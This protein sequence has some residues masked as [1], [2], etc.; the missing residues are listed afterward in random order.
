MREYKVL[1]TPEPIPLSPIVIPEEMK[2]K[3]IVITG[4]DT[5]YDNCFDY[6]Q[7]S[8]LMDQLLKEI[9]TENDSL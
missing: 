9:T 6:E 8:K 5:L 7:Y 3:D 2:H 1:N 4:S